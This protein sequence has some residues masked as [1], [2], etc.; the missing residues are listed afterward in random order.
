MNGRPDR[1]DAIWL[2]NRLDEAVAEGWCLKTNCGTCANQDFRDATGL[3][4]V[5]E[6]DRWVR[7]QLSTAEL[8]E[9]TI[10]LRDLDIPPALPLVFEKGVMWLIY[11]IW[12]NGSTRADAELFPLLQGSY[13]GSI[14]EGMRA[15]YQSRLEA[16]RVH[17]ARQGVKK[18]D[19]KV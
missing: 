15:H 10:A 4:L 19:W 9:L 16:R 3:A 1:I 8:H 14:L 6:P 11:E 5:R 12:R 2:R 7:P 17:E 13:A 18:R